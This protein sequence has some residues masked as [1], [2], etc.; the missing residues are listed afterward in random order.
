MKKYV[1]YLLVLLMCGFLTEVKAQT[2]FQ[3]D[4]INY[5]LD[6]SEARVSDNQYYSGSKIIIPNSVLYD[7]KNYPVTSIA[8]SAFYSNWSLI[9]VT[10][11]NSVTTIGDYAFAS[12]S[13]L[14]TVTIPNSV[15]TIGDYVF[16]SCSGLKTVTIPNAMTSIGRNAFYGCT[17][18][19]EVTIP[20]AVT[21][22]GI[23]AFYGCTGLTEVTI[24]NSVTTIG[25]RAFYR[26]TGLQTVIWNA[27]NAEYYN[28]LSYDSPFSNCDRLTDFVF[29]E[30]VEHIP[31]Y[32]CRELT[33]LNTIVIPN[34]VTSIGIS[35][36]DGC[37]GLTEVIWNA[38][39]VQDFQDNS[40]RPFSGCDRLTDFVFGEE[41]E[42]IPAYLCREL[43]LLN[44]IVIP[45]SVTSI[46][47]NAF[48]FC[49][50]LTKVSI[51]NSVK[52]IGNWAFYRCT[53]LTTVTIGN[54]VTSIGNRAFYSCTSLTEVS[55]PNSVKTIE[56]RAF[57]GCTGLKTVTIGNSVTTIG[58]SAFYSCT[59]LTEVSIP[60]SVT[61]IGSSVFEDC[62]GLKTVTIG[63]SVTTI[64]ESAFY[65]CTS[66]TEVSIP[67]SVTSI[68]SGAFED[69]SGLKTVTI[70]NSV[71][72]IGD[73]TFNGCTSLKTVI[74]N[75]R[76]VQDTFLSETWIPKPPFP[77]S[78][79][80]TEFVFG[81]EVEY[82]P[83]Y[84]CYQLA[85]LKKLVIGNSVTSIGN[86][87][88]FCCSGLTEVTIPNSVTSIGDYAFADCTGLTEITIP[89]AV[90]T[91]EGYAFTR[92]TG[93]KTVTIG[94]SVTTIEDGAFNGC[95]QM[96]SVTIG[97][98]VESIG[99]SAFAKCNSLTA[100]TSKAVTPPQIWA[101]TFDDYAMTLYVP[102]GCKSKYAE[103]KYWRNFTDIRETGVTLHT[104][105]AN[106]TDETMGYVIGAG[107][108]P[109]GSTATLVAV[110][111][112]QN[113]FVRWN[114]GNTDN[115]RTITV[116]GDMTF[117]AEFA[118]AGSAVE[119]LENGER[120]IYAT[121]RTL[122]VE[123]G[124]ESYR[125]Y[126][127]AGRLVYTGNDSSVTLSAPGMYIMRTGD[128]SQKVAVK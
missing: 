9:E 65:S 127:A 10:I 22:I 110:P 113:Y 107:E 125:V 36:F 15:T 118:P 41:V 94:N 114:D 8:D 92:C 76:N 56:F 34:S 117:T 74:W 128:R 67:N 64:G 39:N 60:N 35:A 90:T 29:G 77:D 106:A 61:S 120:G 45:N 58:E 7:G 126:T 52:T 81:E 103:T 88:F 99:E 87:A 66:L 111:F 16:A 71:T 82:I 50:G 72:T 47:T 2:T 28:G 33:L 17:G 53:G 109:Q 70:G 78:D 14:K 62:S 121:G 93:L 30:E 83:A 57:E 119:T 123:N 49:R 48:S 80:L 27:R 105:T 101:T 38:R 11:P 124:G 85:S 31:A 19:T 91:I 3:V 6:G 97:E 5:Y 25:E 68:G 1:R 115:P 13:G 20:N 12:C 55:I 46:G 42:H 43:T 112:G 75:A 100:V 59:S 86:H 108:Y 122:H 102:A 44:T 51:P 104:V 24:P 26:C 73:G 116:T 23:N 37:S 89:N 98:K 40:S 69:C 63:N 4:G 32:L 79:R 18:L 54:S 21:S 96:E 95:T 84:L